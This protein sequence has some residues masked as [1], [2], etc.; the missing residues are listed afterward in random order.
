MT[1]IEA[2][3]LIVGAALIL[4]VIVVIVCCISWVSF[5]RSWRKDND[6]DWE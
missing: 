6:A 2:I 1:I 5:W 4:A 3:L